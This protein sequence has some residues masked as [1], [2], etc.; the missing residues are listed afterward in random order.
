LNVRCD[1]LADIRSSYGLPT[2]KRFFHL[3]IGRL[4]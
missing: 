4:E 1:E 3:T 2:N